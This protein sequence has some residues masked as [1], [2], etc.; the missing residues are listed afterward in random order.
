MVKERLD[1]QTM[2]LRVARELQDGWYVNLGFGI[3]TMVA[4]VIPEGKEVTFVSE[5]GLI[6]FGPIVSK[7]DAAKMGWKY[8]DASAQPVSAAPG[9]AIVDY[10]EAFDIIRGGRLDLTV[11]GGLQVSEKGDL[12]NWRLPTY[13][14]LG[15]TIGGAM[16]LAANCKR[17]Y[18]VMSHTEKNGKPKIVREC[19]YPL[20]AMR[21][22]DLIV[23]D[24][25]VIEMTPDGLLLKELAP[26]WTVEEIQAVTEAKLRISPYL[27]EIEL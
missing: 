10:A 23:T 18:V 9:M 1:D 11:L 26:G 20:T 2:A 27:K 5:N 13:K 6:G 21:C 8:V 16:D 22:V 25:A 7:E 14:G 3:P 12:A 19:S 24:L 17:I 4:N 15:G